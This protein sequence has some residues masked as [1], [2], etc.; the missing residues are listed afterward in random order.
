[1]SGVPTYRD[2]DGLWRRYDMKKVSHINNFLKD[3]VA[4][5]RFELELYRLLRG[6]KPNAGHH[7]LVELEEAGVVKGIVTQNVEGLHTIAGSR[8]VVELHG[9]ET[10][11]LCLRCGARV[12]AEEAFRRIGWLDADNSI[13]EEA[14]TDISTIL[15][16]ETDC[17]A[18]SSSSSPSPPPSPRLRTSNVPKSQKIAAKARSRSPA[19]KSGDASVAAARSPSAD[20]SSSDESSTSPDPVPRG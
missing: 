18:S 2:P 9:N 14:L 12:S 13:V 15:R 10:Q 3:P 11:A 19:A 17:A 16:Q 5:W 6:V 8:N 20:S 7:A 1:E 4:C